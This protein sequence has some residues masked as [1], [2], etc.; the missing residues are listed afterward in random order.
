MKNSCPFLAFLSIVIFLLLIPEDDCVRIIGGNDVIPHSRP[1][2][3]LLKS[4]KDVCAGALIAKKWVLTAAHCIL[5]K[6][7]QV[8]LG[9][10]SI[11]K[12]EPE[13]QITSVKKEFPHPCY[14]KHTHENDIKLLK[15]KKGATI[16]KYVATL[17]L[18]KTGDDVKPGTQCR[19]AGWGK[20]SQEER[21]SETLKEV[22]VTVIDRK[23]C[24]DPQHYNF[25]PVIGLNM[26]CAGNP[27]GGKDTCFGDSGSPLMCDGTFR[28]V[29]S[30]GPPGKCG[31]PRRPGIYMLLSDKYR[32]WIIKTM[33][34]AV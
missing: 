3:V 5:G 13:K 12:N 2:M 31:D 1:Y 10:H 4:Q 15:L 27:R 16:N 24:N 21:L 18:P 28:G 9:A 17:Q 30:F 29:T 20:Y 34:G 25:K 7:S 32:S 8:I 11:S 26:I 33:K 6:K 14:D 22:N 23:I 19:V